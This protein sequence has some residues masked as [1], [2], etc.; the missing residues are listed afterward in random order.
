MVLHRLPY[1]LSDWNVM[2]KN[3][4]YFTVN[5]WGVNSEDE[6]KIEAE[7]VALLAKYDLDEP[8]RFLNWDWLD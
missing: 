1:H 8:I 7:L 6:P 4:R 3:D 2:S 5:L